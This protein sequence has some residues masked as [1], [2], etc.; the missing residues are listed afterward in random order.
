MECAERGPA[1]QGAQGH[2]EEFRL[3]DGNISVAGAVIVVAA[4]IIIITYY[5]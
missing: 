4:E 5:Q 2:A 1:V 3:H